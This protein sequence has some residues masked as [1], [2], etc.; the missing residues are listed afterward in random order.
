MGY[1]ML[2][3]LDGYAGQYGNT[4]RREMKMGRTALKQ[5]YTLGKRVDG[6]RKKLPTHLKHETLL[7][8]RE[9]VLSQLE[10][11]PRPVKR[12]EAFWQAHVAKMPVNEA[13]GRGI[14]IMSAYDKIYP[15][16]VAMQSY[17]RGLNNFVWYNPIS[18]FVQPHMDVQQSRFTRTMVR[19]E[20]Y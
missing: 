8:A 10:K 16:F 6:I 9:N 15:L 18:W 1:I 17:L 20:R 3:I 19:K 12:T 11:I 7:V 2:N 5:L 13:V 4:M 14:W